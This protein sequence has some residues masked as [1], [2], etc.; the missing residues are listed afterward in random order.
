MEERKLVV[1][2]NLEGG[3][4]QCLVGG[5]LDEGLRVPEGLVTPVTVCKDPSSL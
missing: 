3:K 1:V 4:C 5:K 2:V